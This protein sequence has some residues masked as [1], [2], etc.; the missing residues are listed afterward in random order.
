MHLPGLVSFFAHSGLGWLAVTAS[1]VAGLWVFPFESLSIHGLSGYFG[2]SSPENA[3]LRPDRA[4]ASTQVSPSLTF[5]FPVFNQRGV[6]E[7]LTRI[8][9]QMKPGDGVIVVTGNNG[10]ALDL[11]WLQAS[12]TRINEA[13]PGTKVYAMTAGL[14]HVRQIK[15]AN[16]SGIAGV[17][18]DYEPKFPNEPE[19]DY[20][21]AKTQANVTE[22]ARILRGSGL[23]SVLLPT[24]LPLNKTWAQKHGWDYAAMGAEVDLQIIQTQTYC[25]SSESEFKGAVEKATS[26]HSARGMGTAHWMPQVTVDPKAPN[27][28]LPAA[29]AKCFAHAV[30]AGHGRAMVW[31]SPYRTDSALEFLS[32]ARP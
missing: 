20:N 16:I 26:Q 32:L 5:L 23:Q 28:V 31:W 7:L 27:G 4:Q 24:G 12:V 9:P 2:S 3:S 6:D 13:L 17:V 11:A 29:A 10:N 22:F 21:F 18:Y 30:A 25:K 14:E 1:F 8:A 15:E 19:F